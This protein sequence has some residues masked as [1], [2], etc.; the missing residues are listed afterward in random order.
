MTIFILETGADV[1]GALKD[2]EARHEEEKKLFNCLVDLLSYE[3]ITFNGEYMNIIDTK[4][5]IWRDH[6]KNFFSD[7][8]WQQR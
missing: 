1:M 8:L 4:L 3:K 2:R 5:N 6:K 7:A